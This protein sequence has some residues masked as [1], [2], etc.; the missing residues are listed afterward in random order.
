MRYLYDV[1]EEDDN[2]GKNNDADI[3]ADEI[4]SNVTL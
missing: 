3:K 4:G 1:I 2:E